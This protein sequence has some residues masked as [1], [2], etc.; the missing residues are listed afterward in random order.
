MLEPN[1][2]FACDSALSNLDQI[3]QTLSSHIKFYIQ[4]LEFIMN[5]KIIA[6]LKRKFVII[7][8]IKKLK[9][10]YKKANRLKMLKNNFIFYSFKIF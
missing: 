1:K 5:K 10:R 6:I 3:I 9:Q 2:N 4:F 8:D 7:S